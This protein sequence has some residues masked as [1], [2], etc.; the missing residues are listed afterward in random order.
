MGCEV[1]NKDLMIEA[2]NISDLTLKQTKQI[3]G[4][5]EEGVK[6]GT[7]TVFFNPKTKALV[8]NKDADMYEMYKDIAE[9]Y[10]A[11]SYETRRELLDKAPESIKGTLI[12]M[13]N[14][15]KC[16]MI[17][18]ELFRARKNI[19]KSKNARIVLNAIESYDP[20][21]AA[22]LA[23]RYG[24]MQGKRMERAKKKA[25]AGRGV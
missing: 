11:G 12:V 17:E 3:L 20:T 16:R 2:C 18:K 21:T 5:W 14:C 24:V 19:I 4:Q 8:L 10:M 6:I 22:C 1:I 25:A 15:L 7:L 9:K 13:E 23:Y